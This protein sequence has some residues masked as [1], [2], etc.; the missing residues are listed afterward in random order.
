MAHPTVVI[1]VAGLT[2][3]LIG[4]ASPRIA[5]LAGRG[6]LRE[7]RPVLP[8]VT[9][10]VQS[11]MLTGL[12]PSGHGIVGNGWYDR[13]WAEVRFWKQSN[14]LVAGEKVWE[15][16]RARD[17]SVTTCN[18]FWWFNMYSS[19]EYSV[20]PRPIYA[21]DG[22]KIPDV[23]SAPAQ[24]RDNL[25]ERFGRFPL[26]H[27][28]GPASSIASSRWIADA[29]MFVHGQHHPTLTLIY[30]P[31][32]DYALQ[33]LGPDHPQIATHVGEIDAVVGSLIDYF[34]AEGV[35]IV[36]LSEYGI[37]AVSRVIRVNRVLREAGL[38]RVR[39]EAGGELLDA[40]ASRAFAVAD[41]QV[42]HVY[43][44]DPAFLEGVESVCRGLE[45]VAS[46]MRP[47]HERA[48]DLVLVADEGCWFSYDYWLDDRRAPDFARTVDIHRKPGYDPCELFIDPAIT[49]PKLR[50]AAKLVRKAMGFRTLMDVIPLDPSLVRGSH[51]RTETPPGRRPVLITAGGDGADEI[52]CCAVR[53]EIL[54][55]LFDDQSLGVSD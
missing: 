51:G 11:S 13:A 42:A 55:H 19:A 23:Y 1:D 17:P 47:F 21:A 9:C 36:L 14:H 54:S 29:S 15:T 3:S 30:L 10:A 50:I 18:M 8:A 22:R 16:A 31:H 20:T 53:D 5:A 2:G 6:R 49:R 12:E 32:L 44:A 40:G 43:V 35:R 37:E 41:H 27:F 48:G 24:L 34:E 38:L 39:D 4:V 45:G 28:W 7:L 26:F 52:S 25:Q 46:V 33:R